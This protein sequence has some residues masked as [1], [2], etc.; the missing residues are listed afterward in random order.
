MV[1]QPRGAHAA[2]ARA[3]RRFRRRGTRNDANVEV[4]SS[5]KTAARRSPARASR[6]DRRPLRRH[7]HGCRRR[8][9]R[10]RGLRVDLPRGSPGPCREQ[11]AALAGGGLALRRPV[12][13]MRCLGITGTAGKSTTAVL[14]EG[15]PAL[16]RAPGSSATT[17]CSDGVARRWTW[18]G[19]NMPQADQLQYLLSRCATKAHGRDGGHLAPR[20]RSSRR[21]TVRRRGF[22]NLSHEH[23]DDHGSLR[24]TS[25]RSYVVRPGRPR[26]WPRTRSWGASSHHALR[27]DL[28]D[29]RGRRCARTSVRPTSS[30]RPRHRVDDPRPQSGTDAAHSAHRRVQRRGLLALRHRPRRLRDGCRGRSCPSPSALPNESRR[31]RRTPSSSTMRTPP[32]RSSGC[33]RPCAS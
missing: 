10:G 2:V 9:R 17:G 24:R 28:D 33:C 6:P 21:R 25:R 23:L 32:T 1:E 4:A 13:A 5:P 3:A 30:R 18:A 14:L 31:A 16:G 15:S 7:D 11:A 29:L 20:L 26:P 22:T 12:A 19:T 8:R 27:Q